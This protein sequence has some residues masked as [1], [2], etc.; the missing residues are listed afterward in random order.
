MCACGCNHCH[1][2]LHQHLPVCALAWQSLSTKLHSVVQGALPTALQVQ[3]LV[4]AASHIEGT[5]IA[6]ERR[7]AH[8]AAGVDFLVQRV[9]HCVLCR[10]WPVRSNAAAGQFGEAA[11]RR[12]QYEAA[13]PAL[14][15]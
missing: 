10:V 2:A 3:R 4:C 11:V 9:G 5:G 7:L 8:L 1:S 13:T 12:S 6:C 15:C 14:A